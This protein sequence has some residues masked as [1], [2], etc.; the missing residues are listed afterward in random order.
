V[1]Y[2]LFLKG[3]QIL[4][5]GFLSQNA[6]FKLARDTMTVNL[7]VQTL[8]I[9][10]FLRDEATPDKILRDGQQYNP[11]EGAYR[12]SAQTVKTGGNNRRKTGKRGFL[13]FLP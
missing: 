3:L 13:Q 12:F 4:S 8:E 2:Q 6:I 7:R 9:C 5:L 11:C 1:N 10:E